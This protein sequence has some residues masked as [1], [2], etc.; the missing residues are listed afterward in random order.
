MA[1]YS[2]KNRVGKRDGKIREY[3]KDQNE[4]FQSVFSKNCGFDPLAAW[5]NNLVGLTSYL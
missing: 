4:V 1:I 2:S 3:L 5:E